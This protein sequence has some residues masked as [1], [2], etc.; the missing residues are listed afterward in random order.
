M[1]DYE[2][3]PTERPPSD[4]K[5]KKE[6]P[7]GGF[8]Y[9]LMMILFILLGSWLIQSVWTVQRTPVA[10]SFFWSQLEQGNIREVIVRGLSIEGRWKN[11]KDAQ[12]DLDKLAEETKALDKQAEDTKDDSTAATDS[13][14]ETG[15]EVKL[16]DYFSTEV[17]PY[18]D[19]TMLR[20]M[21]EQNVNVKSET[22]G[23]S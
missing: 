16:E 13:D 4:S 15:A 12:A 3:Q 8:P 18:E 21:Q 17:P 20:L 5:G 23:F 11:V 9:F 10:Y 6:P 14:E 2:K 19:G 7:R 22:N 1:S